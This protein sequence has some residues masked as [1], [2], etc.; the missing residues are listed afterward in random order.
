MASAII[1]EKIQEWRQKIA[2]GTMSN[3]EMKEALTAIRKERVG[4]SEVSAT[5]RA[6]RA[7]AKEKLAAI[8]SDKLLDSFL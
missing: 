5:A 3:E 6:K 4:A 7:T 1:N 2:A 8:D